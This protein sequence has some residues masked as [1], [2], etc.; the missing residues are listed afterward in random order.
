MQNDTLSRSWAGRLGTEGAFIHIAVGWE[1][2]AWES[3][4]NREESIQGARLVLYELRLV[5]FDLKKLCAIC[6]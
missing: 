5:K 6:G 1:F 2:V 4:E 3:N